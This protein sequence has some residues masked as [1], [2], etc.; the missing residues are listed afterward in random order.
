MNIEKDLKIIERVAREKND[1]NW[2]FRS[3]LKRHDY[4]IDVSI[5]R[6]GMAS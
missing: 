5:Q 2:E 1:E 4:E 6:A 3:F